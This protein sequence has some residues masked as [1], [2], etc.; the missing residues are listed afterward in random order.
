MAQKILIVDDEAHIRM[1]IEQTLEELEDEGVEF[2]TAENG[3]DALESRIAGGN[4]VRVEVLAEIFQ[5]VDHA[6]KPQLVDLMND[7]EEQLV[8]LGSGRNRLLGIE[9]LIDLE[10]AGVGQRHILLC[11]ISDRGSPIANLTFGSGRLFAWLCR[12]RT[13]LLEI[14]ASDS[15]DFEIDRLAAD[16]D[17]VARGALVLVTAL[18]GDSSRANVIALQLDLQSIDVL[19]IEEIFGEELDRFARDPFAAIL[20]IPDDVAK[21]EGIVVHLGLEEDHLSDEAFRLVVDDEHHA[22]IVRPESRLRKS[23]LEG[24]FGF[25]GEWEVRTAVREIARQFVIFVEV[26]LA[27]GAQMDCL[28]AEHRKSIGEC[29]SRGGGIDRMLGVRVHL[30]CVTEG[31]VVSGLGEYSCSPIDDHTF[32][33]FRNQEIAEQRVAFARF[34]EESRRKSI[35][36]GFHDDP[37]SE[38]DDRMDVGREVDLD[39]LFA[40][41]AHTLVVADKLQLFRPKREEAD[42]FMGIEEAVVAARGATDEDDRP[43]R[44]WPTQGQV[45]HRVALDSAVF[46]QAEEIQGDPTHHLT[47]DHEPE[48]R[49]N[50]LGGLDDEVHADR[51]WGK[52]KEHRH[53]VA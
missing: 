46:E 9:K 23:L 49:A 21:F 24:R 33:P 1:L 36:H 40:R 35:D 10:I 42:V 30:G 7:D 48:A 47:S 50:H 45:A 44:W 52:P 15:K 14:L 29:G 39:D 25:D 32:Q 37:A 16:D 28:T 12:L 53:Q 19:Q 18:L 17:G 51:G 26:C 4:V 2:L 6:L 11:A 31:V 13:E 38:A 3:Q 27:K 22:A 20:G 5:L 43:R 41:D 34:Q 8:V